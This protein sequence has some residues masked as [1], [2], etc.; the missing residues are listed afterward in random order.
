MAR[1]SSD[2]RILVAGQFCHGSLEGSYVRAFE[3]EGATV[4]RFDLNGTVAKYTRLGRVG[5]LFNRFSPIEAWI[6]KANRDLV[7]AT[8]AFQPDFLMVG[9]AGPVRAGALAQIRASAPRTRLLMLWPDTLLRLLPHVSPCLPLYDLV[10]SYSSSAV[11][12]F[13]RLGAPLVEWVPLGADLELHPA[14]GTLTEE[15]RRVYG[16]DVTFVGNHRP[17]REE[18]FLL[19]LRAGFSVKVWGPEDWRR[20]SRQPGEVKKYWQ[21]RSLYGE[22]FAKAVRCAHVALNPIDP[23]NYPAANMRFFEVPACRGIAL[24]SACPEMEPIF[25]HRGST[26]YYRSDEELVPLL[27]ELLAKPDELARIAHAAHQQVADAHTYRHRVRQII[28]LLAQS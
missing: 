19:L 8:A 13:R 17:E 7:V 3:L 11:E 25:P 26:L 10:A 22:G 2:Y 23:T 24:N 4:K 12:P 1:S 9:G 16:C 20:G 5:A 28:S 6:N 21:G 27:R 14:A 15:D 18:T